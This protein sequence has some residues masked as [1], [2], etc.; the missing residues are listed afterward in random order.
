M[1]NGS[2]MSNIAAD[3]KPLK[4]RVY[5]ESEMLTVENNHQPKN[6]IEPSSG[7]G[8]NNISQR[9]E[10]LFEKKIIIENNVDLFRVQLP[11]IP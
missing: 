3:Y 1:I 10:L 8:L 4:I 9:Y 5:T 7:I 11:L 2:G 6:S